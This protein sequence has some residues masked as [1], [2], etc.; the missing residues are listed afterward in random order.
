MYLV[1]APPPEKTVLYCL[2]KAGTRFY[3][4]NIFISHII[5]FTDN[6]NP[7]IISGC[8]SDQSVTTDSGVA[9]AEVTWTSPTATDNF[10]VPTLTSTHNS[11]DDFPIG[12]NTVT[13]TATDGAGNTETCTFSVVVSGKCSSS[14]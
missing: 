14:A 8:P 6:E 2:V 10:G 5:F 4:C 7:V 11:G 1:N 9:T 12:S 3:K 13:Y